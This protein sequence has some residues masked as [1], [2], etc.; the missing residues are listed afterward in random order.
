MARVVVLRG[1]GAVG[2][3]A[4]FASCGLGRINFDDI[5]QLIKYD[6]VFQPDPVNGEIYA[7]LMHEFLNIKTNN[8][9]MYDRL[10]REVI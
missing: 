6:R 5:P 2:R 10:N 1:S 7:E 4:F 9:K 3:A 8:R